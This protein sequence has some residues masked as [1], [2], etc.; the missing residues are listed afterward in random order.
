MS[1]SDFEDMDCDEFEAVS[2]VWHEREESLRQDAWERAR[3]V[4]TLSVSP[5]MKGSVKPSKILPLPWDKKN[6]VSGHRAPFV[7]KE[8][9]KARLEKLIRLIR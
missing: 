2:S 4:G 7:S 6:S 9:D 1:V 5:W 8:E 3:I